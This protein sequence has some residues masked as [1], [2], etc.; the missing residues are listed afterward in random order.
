VPRERT[1]TKLELIPA[2]VSGHEGWV[3]ARWERSDGSKGN[4]T[5]AFRRES[6]DRWFIS[7]L[8]VTV[9]TSELLR[10]VPLARIK[11][12]MNADSRIRE[13]VERSAEPL[14]IDAQGRP[15]WRRDRLKRPAERLLDD[16][17]YARVATAYIGAVAHGLPP[18]K[19]L[20][21]DS[22]T[23]AGTVNRWIAKARA[24]GFL[25]PGEPGKVT[26]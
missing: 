3:E 7:E 9:P 15:I 13:W 8:L 17:F 23:P 6:A 2:I 12:A 20:A 4:A 26:A 21:A 10:D 19:T 24:C 16:A 22:D 1:L 25:P 5:A 11:A 18:A 14:D